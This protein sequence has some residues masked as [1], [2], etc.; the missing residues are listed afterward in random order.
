LTP[1]LTYD[2]STC[3]ANFSPISAITEPPFVED[4]KRLKRY[5]GMG[6]IDAM[7]KGSDDRYFG[8]TS[9]IKVGD[10]LPYDGI[11]AKWGSQIETA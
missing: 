7:K 9:A 4:G 10:H 5:R 3:L 8:T 6:S 1:H 2:Y 11:R